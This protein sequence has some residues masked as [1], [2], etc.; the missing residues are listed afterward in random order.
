[1]TS[2]KNRTCLYVIAVDFNSGWLKQ[3]D[4]FTCD[5]LYTDGICMKCLLRNVCS[6]FL[7]NCIECA[8][9]PCTSFDFENDRFTRGHMRILLIERSTK[10]NQQGIKHKIFCKF[11]NS[12][13]LNSKVQSITT[14][15]SDNEILQYMIKTGYQF[16]IHRTIILVYFVADKVLIDCYS[17]RKFRFYC[18]QNIVWFDSKSKL[19]I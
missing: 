16:S 6:Y 15:W 8:L 7:T 4:V 14:D 12:I 17:I 19:F 1:M 9:S 13:F 2:S 3:I 10:R 11:I 5:L 18:T